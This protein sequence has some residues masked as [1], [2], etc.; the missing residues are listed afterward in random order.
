MG[1]SITEGLGDPISPS[2]PDAWRGWADRLA[3]VLA[4]HAAAAGHPFAYANLAVRSRR[5]ADVVDD[6]I[7]LALA[8]NA[9]LVSIMVGANDLTG[10]AADPDRLAA[11][12][13]QGVVAL[14]K[15]GCTVLLANSF[16]PH[17]ATVMRPL[18]GRAAIFNSHVWTIAATHG[19]HIID[20]WGTRA[21]QRH[22]M[23]SE[24]R[25][26]LSPR[27]HALVARLSANALGVHPDTVAS[28]SGLLADRE[29]ASLPFHSW[30]GAHALP[31]VARRL[32]GKAA[33]D[34]R[35]PKRPH[36]QPVAPP[37]RVPAHHNGVVLAPPVTPLADE[38]MARH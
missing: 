6:Q 37:S 4:A 35:S 12:L 28:V 32:R 29:S 15:I 38:R 7:P 2:M 17:F 27:G 13:E 30:L 25:V 18:R 1:D 21:L 20:L 26:H 36:L 24:D 8:Q 3:L 22:D 11:N 9:D 19:A 14:R 23:R 16:D 33:G 10:R 31:W 5:V 34:G